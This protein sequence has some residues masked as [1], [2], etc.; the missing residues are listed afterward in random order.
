MNFIFLSK[1]IFN[2]DVM[3]K[4]PIVKIIDWY[5][6][7]KKTEINDPDAITLATVDDTG[8][9]NVRTVLLRKIDTD[10]FVF[11]TN[12][13]SQKGREI[14][15]NNKI[16][17]SFYWKTLARQVRI[18]GIAE[19]ENSKVA[20]DYYNSRALGSRIG[21]WASK[22]SAVLKNRDELL[23]RISLMEKKFK[24]N[25]P[26]PDFWGGIRIRPLS[27][28]FWREG[29]FRLHERE[30]WK[31]FELNQEWSIQKLYP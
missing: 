31:R 22:Q 1:I 27:I 10:S 5:N 20:D 13:Y 19:K 17:F 2:G 16:A 4:N 21:A 26:K 23:E 11:F 15:H 3:D 14:E 9:P 6:E 12:Y 24:S 30:L 8:F 7:A 28:E 18:R 25:P 29:K